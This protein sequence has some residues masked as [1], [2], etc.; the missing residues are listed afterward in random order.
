M[1]TRALLQSLHG[2]DGV[3][4]LFRALGYPIAPIDIDAEEWRRGG[5]AL[6]WSN[7]KLQLAARLRR[8][9]LFVLDGEADEKAIADFM[10]SY[11]SYNTLT[12]SALIH[13]NSHVA[14]F[15]RG[16]R[17]ALRRLD[18]DFADPS[19]HAID[20]LNL[21]AFGGEL[22]LP[23]IFER[24]LDRESVTRQFFQRFRAAVADVS[25]ALPQSETKEARDG[26]AL[27]L[28]SRLLFL[29][30][31]QKKGWL[32]GERRFLVDHLEEATQRGREFFASVLLPLFFG[33]L[34]T[35][36][37]KRNAAARR[38]GRIPYLNGGLFEPSAFEQRHPQLHLPN[39]LLRRVVEDV[40]ERFDFSLDERDPAGMHVDPEMLGRVFESLMAEDERAE[41]GSF[42]TPREIVDTL[43]GEAI[44]EWLGEGT[45]AAQLAKLERITV[46]DPACGSGAFLLS[47][48]SVIEELTRELA[49]QCDAEVPRD[50]RRRIVERNLFGVDLKPEAVRLCELRLW[51]AIVSASDAEIDEVEPLPN[52]DR[53]ILQGN[54]LLSPTDFLGDGRASI[55]RDWLHALHAQRDLVERYRNAPRAERPALARLIRTNDQ[56]LASDLL[57]RAIDAA[58]AE[59]QR[60]IAPQR[61]L[62]GRAIPADVEH[63]HELQQRIEETRR[64]LDRAEEGELD[65][66]S[67]DIHFAPVLANGGFDVVA[68]NPPWVRH[69]RIEP[70]MRR[71]LADRYAFF[72]GARDGTAFHQPDLSV[73]FCERALSLA[74]KEGVIAL[75]LP[76]KIVNAAYAAPLRRAAHSRLVSIADWSDDPRRHRWFEA[77]TFPLG[78]VLRATPKREP[79]RVTACG[80]TFVARELAFGEEWALVP[81]EVGAIL[82]RLLATHR[83]LE[84]VLRRKPIMGIKT[85]DNRSFFLTD[86]ELKRF[87]IPATAICRCVRGRDLQRWRASVS[88]WMLWPPAHGWKK[89]PRWLQALASDRGVEPDALRLAFVKPEHVGIKVAW[90]D[91]SRG[92]AA[93]VLPDVVTIGAQTFPL[94]PNQTLYSLDAVSYDEAYGLAAILNSVVANAL[95]LCTAE[96]AKDAHYRYFGRTVARLPIP[97]AAN[98]ERLIRLSRRAHQGANTSREIDRV[99]AELY[100]LS[101]REVELLREFVARRLDAR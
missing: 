20:R 82:R 88:Q 64:A 41:S 63:C 76:Q 42:Y 99:V 80:E 8:F 43:T 67:F 65:F 70:R 1:I 71:Q 60:V 34:N 73:A 26:E 90:K 22:S 40:F 10:N 36:A 56:R 15:D 57:A 75:L 100:G 45:P 17:G 52:L 85:G 92:M 37:S 84:T 25:A 4:A 55:Y 29:T 49:A 91:L 86:E 51:L 46:L 59:L 77:D 54:S 33:C 69:G 95:L 6:G 2:T 27:L 72:R 38:L 58:E 21:L 74:S 101:A 11:G 53:N 3:Y 98:D 19:P 9:D 93:A 24:A 78:A 87:R 7:A 5:V 97:D 89:T 94:V 23:R 32:N 16:E 30:F 96:R 66:F 12:K 35:P 61:D 31:V 48:L 81:P 68:G 83:A 28:L 47:A 44:R 18:V 50:L 62:F 14:I 13:V 79:V 39:E